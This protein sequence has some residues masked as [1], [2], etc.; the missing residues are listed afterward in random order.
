[1][2]FQAARR[3]DAAARGLAERMSRRAGGVE[4]TW[5]EHRAVRAER[6]VQETLAR[7][8]VPWS[9]ITRIGS[10]K[11]VSAAHS[12]SLLCGGFFLRVLFGSHLGRGVER[13]RPDPHQTEADP[14][15]DEPLPLPDGLGIGEG[16]D[17]RAEK[18]GDVASAAPLG[19]LPAALGIVAEREGAA[20]HADA[21]GH[22]L[23]GPALEAVAQRRGDEVGHEASAL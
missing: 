9:Y 3:G 12:R 17:P 18:A 19:D 13:L 1:M 10:P 15:E 4:P 7:T 6:G 23:A 11:S 22:Q 8:Y 21:H 14:E 20:D 16:F 5:A 2:E